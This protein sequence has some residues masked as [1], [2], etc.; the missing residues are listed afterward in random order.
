[1]D[2]NITE[3]S[4]P[5]EGQPAYGNN[6]P[7]TATTAT[8]ITVD[9]GVAGS[10][11]TF[12]PTNA[13]YDPSTGLLVLTI[14]SHNLTIDEGIVIANDALTFTCTM[15]GNQSQKTY[16]RASTDYAAERSL[17]IVAIGAETITVDVG[18]AGAN[19]TFTATDATYVPSTGVMELTVGQPVSYTHLTLPTT[20][21]V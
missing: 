21:Y 12:T 1:M 15:D 4:Y 20:P 2:N 5:Q 8:T 19:R 6:R 13:T 17:P 18:T 7:V 11:L 10:N 3:H 14:G 9:V 16:P